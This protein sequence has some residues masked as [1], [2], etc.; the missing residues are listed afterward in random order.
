MALTVE[1][2]IVRE[3][4]PW[5]ETTVAQDR[6]A[7][8]VDE[9]QGSGDDAFDYTNADGT[10]D[11]K[12]YMRAILRDGL[13]PGLREDIELLRVFMRAFNLLD[14][15]TDL[16]KRPDL[17]AR[18]MAS[19]ARKDEREPID[20]GPS[21]NIVQTADY[22]V[23]MTKESQADVMK[24]IAV[25]EVHGDVRVD[26]TRPLSRNT[27]FRSSQVRFSEQDCPGQI[28]GFNMIKINNQ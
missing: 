22:Q 1:E 25:H 7:I 5:Y 27:G 3:I 8:D 28:G 4:V 21:R 12:K 2:D 17:L 16:M 23:R 14:A 9:D 20:M 15:A 26:L 11:P 6:D 10:I 24:D 13:L 18:V 19:Y